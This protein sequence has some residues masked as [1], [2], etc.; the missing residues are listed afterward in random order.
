M[1]RVQPEYLAN[2]DLMVL[3]VLLVLMAILELQET[4]AVQG[5]R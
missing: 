1:C 4:M 5:R 3:R 2:P